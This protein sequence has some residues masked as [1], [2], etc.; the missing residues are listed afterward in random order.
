M[1]SEMSVLGLCL[2]AGKPPL[3]P[4]TAKA[5]LNHS[6]LDS[7]TIRADSPSNSCLEL[8]ISP[9]LVPITG[10]KRKAL[11]QSPRRGVFA[12]LLLLCQHI[13]SQKREFSAQRHPGDTQWLKKLKILVRS[14]IISL[15]CPPR[16][17]L[18]SFTAGNEVSL[19]ISRPFDGHLLHQFSASYT[20]LCLPFAAHLLTRAALSIFDAYLKREHRVWWSKGLLFQFSA[21][22]GT[23]DVC[24]HL[25]DITL[26]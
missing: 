13:S 21:Q 20:S 14:C 7:W 17:G 16:R 9:S 12:L 10:F 1:C 8:Y 18:W 22:F 26:L 2:R 24:D 3:V 6:F 25:I 4:S 15:R 5:F 19:P 23:T 11:Y